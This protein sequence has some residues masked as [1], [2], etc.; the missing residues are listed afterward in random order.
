MTQSS[1]K[2]DGKISIRLA[3]DE[4]AA[5][6]ALCAAGNVTPSEAV[7]ILIREKAGLSLPVAEADRELL[8]AADQHFRKIGVSLNQ[9]IRTMNQGSVA[10]QAPLEE[11]L[12]S[13]IGG[14]VQM[15]FEIGRLIKPVRKS[16]GAQSAG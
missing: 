6:L 16:E 5:L 8:K 1:Q 10:Y 15:R 14:L 4:Q 12:K 13:L 11:G 3:V 9:A 7:R 2:S